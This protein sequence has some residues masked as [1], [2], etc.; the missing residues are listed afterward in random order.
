MSWL[1]KKVSYASC[2]EIS[3]RQ[4]ETGR[5]SQG[6]AESIMKLLVLHGNM[7]CSVSSL[8]AAMN[9]FSLLIPQESV[10]SCLACYHLVITPAIMDLLWLPV[11]MSVCAK[12]C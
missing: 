5:F 1:A 6:K 4:L 7:C 8:S 11:Q 2:L 10:Q 12:W 9:S 3:M